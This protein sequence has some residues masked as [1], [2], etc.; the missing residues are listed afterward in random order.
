M[1]AYLP[2]FLFNVDVVRNLST[3]NKNIE[4]IN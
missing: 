2:P 4:V 3:Q 1:A